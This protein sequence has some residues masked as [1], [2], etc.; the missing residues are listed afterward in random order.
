[1]KNKTL[2]FLIIILIVITIIPYSEFCQENAKNSIFLKLHKPIKIDGDEDFTR[3]N[4]VKSGS[5][6]ITD[7]YIIS[8]WKIRPVANNG[9]KIQNTNSYF[10]VE[11]C[12]VFG[13]K[14]INPSGIFLKNVSN[15]KILNCACSKAGFGLIMTSSSNNLV[16]GFIAKNCDYGLTING[17]PTGDSPSTN[18]N[19]VRNSF[20]SNCGNGTYFCCLPN[21]YNNQIENCKF[22]KNTRGILIDHLTSY[23]KIIGCNFSDNNIGLKISKTSNENY[24]VNNVFLNNN[25]HAISNCFTYWDN[26]PT[27]GGNFWSDHDYDKPY[28]ITGMAKNVDNFP[29]SEPSEKNQLLAFFKTDI[30]VFIINKKINFDASLSY[31]SDSITNYSWNFDDVTIKN[32]KLVNHSYSSTGIFNISLNI[33]NGESFDSFEKQIKVIELS[34]NEIIV[35]NESSIQNAINASMPGDTIIVQPG[36]YYETLIIDKPYLSIIGN[37]YDEVV[38]DGKKKDNVILIKSSN[39]KISN[40]TIMNSSKNKAGIWIESDNC[41]IANNF[42]K[43]NYI[44]VEIFE[45]KNIHTISNNFYDNYYGLFTN[46]SHSNIFLFNN[47]T[48]NCIAMYLYWGSNWNQIV[49]NTYIDNHLGL[50]LIWSH[51]SKIFENNIYQNKGGIKLENALS[52]KINYNNIHKN[53]NFGICYIGGIG[54]K[55]Y[56]N[57]WWGSRFGPSGKLSLFGDQIFSEGGKGTSPKFNAMARIL[58]CYPWEKEEIIFS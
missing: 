18:N 37:N 58:S 35:S 10:K 1:M 25:L 36:K 42:I 32:G 52:S 53:S 3:L 48:L 28:N 38:I 27:Y 16:D 14:I 9:I 17:C 13:N 47:F 57:N 8:N 45:T 29:L 41:I 11:N 44:G 39:V 4:G 26:G 55:D 34:N 21:S 30:N 43:R 12:S 24:I 2:V 40:L 19:I 33:T 15:G 50:Y 22:T 31:E 7:P 5:G 51:Y 6:S 20:F 54:T 49:R 46:S 23:V 56:K